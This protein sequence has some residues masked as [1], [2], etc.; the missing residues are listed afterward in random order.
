MGEEGESK[1]S[2]KTLQ[3]QESEKKKMVSLAFLV[4]PS[5]ATASILPIKFDFGGKSRP[6]LRSVQQCEVLQDDTLVL[7][8]G[9]TPDEICMPGTTLINTHTHKRRPTNGFDAEPGPS[10]DHA[11]PHDC[12]L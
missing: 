10:Q 12:P 5:L 2:R 8:E 3:K 1:R 11:L 6:N 7:I 9:T 4:L